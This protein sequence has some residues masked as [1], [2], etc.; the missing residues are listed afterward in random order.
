LVIHEETES[1]GEGAALPAQGRTRPDAR[2][3]NGAGDALRDK[4]LK[5]NR[6]A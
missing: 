2:D 3:G 6:A 5:A 4:V 1:G